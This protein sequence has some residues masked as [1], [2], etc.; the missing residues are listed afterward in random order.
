MI[1]VALVARAQFADPSWFGA[2]SYHHAS[3]V[4]EGAQR[5]MADVIRSAGAANLMNSAAAINY[6]TAKKAYIENRM[7]TTQTYFDMQKV[8]QEARKEKRGPAPTQ[9]QLI[10]FSKQGLPARIP[11][12]QLDPVT[13]QIN[14][15]LA[16]RDPA[17]KAGT[18]ALQVLFK[19]RAENG[20][21]SPE[22]YLKI[23][24]LCRET[25]DEL[26]RRSTNLPSSQRI[27]ARKFLESLAYESNMQP[28]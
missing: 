4:Q 28:A 22:Q 27:A 6:Q 3:T 8:N 24:Q 2:N 9:E 21:L 26:Q 25:L 16:L 13:G 1:A 18:D 15:P 11:A 5:G 7:L 14:W 20:Y 10:R 23:Q 12:S 19:S 17:Y